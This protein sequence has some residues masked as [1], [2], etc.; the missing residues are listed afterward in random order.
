MKNNI[1]V[2]NYWLL[3]LILVVA[4]IIISNNIDYEKNYTGS[5]IVTDYN[6]MK[7]Y[8][9]KID[10]KKII[11]NKKIIIEGEDFAYK[12]ILINNVLFDK[13]YY[14]EI[15]IDVDLN[16]KLNIKN[17]LLDFKISLE[18]MTIFKYILYKIGGEKR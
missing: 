13:D 3:I 12:N 9:N 14:F 4:F 2:N 1:S 17:N 6:K 10:L 8:C 7:I 16:N 15:Y 18:K 11:D 5:G